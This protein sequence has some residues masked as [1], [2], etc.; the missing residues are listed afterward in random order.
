MMNLVI[1]CAFPPHYGGLFTR[2]HVL[3]NKYKQLKGRES[4]SLRSRAC[5]KQRALQ[6]RKRANEL[7]AAAIKLLHKR[8]RQLRMHKSRHREMRFTK[9]G[10]HTQRATSTHARTYP[11]GSEARRRQVSTAKPA[12]VCARLRRDPWFTFRSFFFFFKC[13]RTD[14]GWK[15]LMRVPGDGLLSLLLINFYWSERWC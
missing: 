5:C 4:Y 7:F 3:T 10:L 12:F 1:A 8:P 2:P 15:S 13:S 11:M 14:R 9:V 6:A